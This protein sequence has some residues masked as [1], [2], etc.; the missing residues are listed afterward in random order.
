MVAFPEQECLVVDV[1]DL[2]VG[3]DRDGF[4]E[5]SNILGA[6]GVVFSQLLV[7]GE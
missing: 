2:F 1:C 5:S 4:D 7:L 3:I 6:R